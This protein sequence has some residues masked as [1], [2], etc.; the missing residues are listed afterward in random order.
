MTRK[1]LM[2]LIRADIMAPRGRPAPAFHDAISRACHEFE[3]KQ[4]FL[5][6]KN[7]V[8]TDDNNKKIFQ[9]KRSI[10]YENIS[11][12]NRSHKQDSAR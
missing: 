2:M 5:A 12:N 10:A 1:I 4:C 11:I 8:A 6:E 9:S 3:I 7:N